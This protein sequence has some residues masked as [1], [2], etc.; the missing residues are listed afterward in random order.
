MVAGSVVARSPAAAIAACTASGGGACGRTGTATRRCAATC[1]YAG[2]HTGSAISAAATIATSRRER[3][4]TRR[5]FDVARREANQDAD[6]T[7]ADRPLLR[8]DVPVAEIASGEVEGH[9]LALAWLQHH[10]LEASEDLDWSV[11]L[12]TVSDA[13]L[14]SVRGRGLTSLAGCGK[15]RY[16]WGTAAPAIFPV[17]LTLVETV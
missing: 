10:L 16:S 17:L 9:G 11:I 15:P 12:Y 13:M 2:G 7:R 3:T 8:V 5:V 1:R 6:L 4:E 14:S